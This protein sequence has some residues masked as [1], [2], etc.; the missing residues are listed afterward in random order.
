MSASLRQNV[1]DSGLVGV[2]GAD[3]MYLD[4]MTDRQFVDMGEE[5]QA[6]IL[7]KNCSGLE[8]KIRSA[9]SRSEAQQV[10]H[11]ACETLQD[12]CESRMVRRALVQ[13]MEELIKEYWGKK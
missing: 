11:R 4:L 8:E 6:L 3:L 9:G 10:G 13:R 1:G 5:R 12:A 7:A 2:H